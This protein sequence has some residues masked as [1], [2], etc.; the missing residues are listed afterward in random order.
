MRLNLTKIAAFSLVISVT[1]CSKYSLTLND[2]V[3]YTPAP[4]FKD[5][6]IADQN[7]RNCVAQ[8]IVDREIKTAQQL[9][10]LV[11]TS[12]GIESLAGLDTFKQLRQLNL[13]SNA[14]QDL[15]GITGL[16]KLE[17]L[18]VS[19]NSIK[20]ASALLKLLSLKHLNIEQNATL[21]CAEIEQLASFSQAELKLPK[22]CS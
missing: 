5:Y 7:L 13:N 21:R 14:L 2:G 15:N 17:A 10:R 6:T 16:S 20:D 11:C 4:L 19:E 1:A 12:A 8:T 22:H 3:V 9:Q 18:D